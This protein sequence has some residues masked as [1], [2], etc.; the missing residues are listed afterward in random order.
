[1]NAFKQ[2]CSQTHLRGKTGE[3]FAVEGVADNA[4]VGLYARLLIGCLGMAALVVACA[5]N[6]EETDPPTPPIIQ[7]EGEEPVEE[8]VP[9]LANVTL[10][11]VP[12]QAGCTQVDYEVT[13]TQPDPAN[14]AGPPKQASATG[15]I[16]E[17]DSTFQTPN[18]DSINFAAPMKICVEITRVIG[19]CPGFSAGQTWC[20]EGPRGSTRGR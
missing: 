9:G 17:E 11:D 10:S 4:R 15:A 5:S 18:T 14:P 13:I 2:T 3:A 6:P 8:F 20:Y 19:F 16:L 1:M 12:F 7:P